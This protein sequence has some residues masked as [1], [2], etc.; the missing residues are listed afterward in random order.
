MK[1]QNLWACGY[2]NFT[3]YR[4]DNGNL[5]FASHEPQAMSYKY[6]CDNKL[7]SA[8]KGTEG[9][10]VKYDPM[11]NRIVRNTGTATHRKYVV[12]ISGD[13]P[14]I[15]VEI[16]ADTGSLKRTYI[17]ANS[18]ILCQHNGDYTAARYYY[19]HDRLGSVR[20]IIDSDGIV[21]NHYTYDPWG[22]VPTG[23]SQETVTNLY[24]FAN[25]VWDAEPSLYYCINRIYDPVLW[26]FTTEDPVKGSYIET[27]TLHR[28]LYVL[29]NPI[30]S[31]DPIGKFGI[32]VGGLIPETING[33]NAYYIGLD[34]G[35]QLAGGD[36]DAILDVAINMNSFRETY[37]NYEGRRKP[38]WLLEIPAEI[39]LKQMLNT[40]DN[41]A[42]KIY[43]S[44]NW[45]PLGGCLALEVMGLE[46]RFPG[47]ARA[48]ISDCGACLAAPPNPA[49]LPC[50]GCI[51]VY[52]ASAITCISK[53]CHGF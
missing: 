7:R 10:S 31:K 41:L 40:I 13:L 30:N 24:R 19:L 2:D 16:D 8:T 38:V 53:N 29:N 15:L 36:W 3:L 4:N 25:Y 35:F 45:A 34:E 49:C 5:V 50:I 6:N 33:M 23:E 1:R 28:Y 37:F 46:R 39:Y 52:G 47:L 42:N 17:Y 18:E 51:S 27:L 43:N 48:C 12:D 21:K 9:I 11:G 32:G 22:L 44:C 14:T 20:M 26:R